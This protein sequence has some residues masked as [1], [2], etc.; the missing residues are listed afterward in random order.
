[1]KPI[2]RIH[3]F[4]ITAFAFFS[5]GQSADYALL[6]KPV[7]KQGCHPDLLVNDK[8][9]GKYQ[10]NNIYKRK[11]VK[12]Q[13]ILQR[14]TGKPVTSYFKIESDCRN[15]T[16]R[17]TFYKVKG[18]GKDRKFDVK[19]RSDQGGNVT[20]KVTRGR[21]ILNVTSRRPSLLSQRVLPK[22]SIRSSTSKRLTVNV[23]HTMNSARRDSAQAIVQA[24]RP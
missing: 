24:S 21:L 20:A 12:K 2:I 16:S 11:P 17:S 14:T 23:R 7:V 22:R 13:T 3:L 1:M 9:R 6:R 4:T 8:K 15:A 5:E 10:G 19:Y 18:T